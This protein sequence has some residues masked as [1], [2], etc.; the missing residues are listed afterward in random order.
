MRGHSSF[1]VNKMM[2][3][4][5]QLPWI[6]EATSAKNIH[7]REHEAEVHWKKK[8]QVQ[9]L[10]QYHAHYY[11]LYKKNMTHTMVSL[12]GLHLGKAFRCLNISASVG[13]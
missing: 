7:S 5:D 4:T 2:V 10:K 1:E 8:I 11:Q 6:K 12:Q 13:L 9:Y 3:Q